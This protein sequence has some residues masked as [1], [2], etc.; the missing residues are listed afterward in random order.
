LNQ[1]NGEIDMAF[2]Y[3]FD[4]ID[5]GEIKDSVKRV[6]SN[7]FRK[8]IFSDDFSTGLVFAGFGD[9]QI[10]P[11]Y[12]SY[13]IDGI[14]ANR[15]RISLYRVGHITRDKSA[16]VTPYAQ[17]DMVVRFMEGVDPDYN[18]YIQESVRS[19]ADSI[20]NTTIDLYG[21][22]TKKFKQEAKLEL[23]RVISRNLSEM[24]REARKYRIEHF[25]DPI[26]SMV[27]MLT[28]SDMAHLAES[29]VNLTSLKRR[30][31]LDEESVGGPID[32][33]VISKGDGFIWIKRKH[34]F[35]SSLNGNFMVN[36]FRNHVESTGE[37]G[38]DRH[39]KK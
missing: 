35:D 10:F 17:K 4:E 27:Q 3:I 5:V 7:A 13:M 31:S 36:Y 30:M 19:F 26:T 22:G 29:L 8:E 33:A 16:I 9:T 21:K 39:A 38:H 6:V 28:K 34:Y 25:V 23:N 24:F 32:V 11:S 15:A 1:Y 14:I 20:V 2:K 12:K 18:S 37:T